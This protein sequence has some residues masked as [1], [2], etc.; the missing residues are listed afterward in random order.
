MVSPP[1]NGFVME[2]KIQKDGFQKSKMSAKR[3]RELFSS[4]TR[5]NVLFLNPF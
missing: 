4:L 1:L 3:K 2:G 5:F